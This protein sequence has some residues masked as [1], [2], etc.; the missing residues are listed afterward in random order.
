M[1]H[2]SPADGVPTPAA[3]RSVDGE[4][5]IALFSRLVEPL[6]RALPAG[7]EVTLHDHALVPNSIVAIHGSV[8]G[9]EVGDP[10][11]ELLLERITAASDESSI[12]Y[13]VSLPDGR[14]LRS[15]A[16]IIRDVAGN[17]VGS[18]CISVDVSVWQTVEAVAKSMLGT[19]A[20]MPSATG[21]PPQTRP[22]QPVLTIADESA[23]RGADFASDMT[24]VAKLMISR[25]VAA[26]DLPVVNMKKADKIAVVR[27]LKG[28][29]VFL[30]KDA[31]NH[32]AEALGVTRFT[33]YNYLNEIEAD[34]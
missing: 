25:E 21:T 10:S 29:G 8:T 13:E 34:D 6:G 5:L 14:L 24:E 22:K 18:L 1:A 31:V 3:W 28:R 15:S 11:N 20:S 2:Q 7:T 4:R 32:V 17:A 30:L 33:I 12:E 19:L 26:A 23:S 27:A 9:R 16:L